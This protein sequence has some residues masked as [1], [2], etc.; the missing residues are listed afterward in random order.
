M[1]MKQKILSVR[2]SWKNNKPSVKEPR[3][4]SFLN[5]RKGRRKDDSF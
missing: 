5:E 1:R 3:M 4:F 2:H